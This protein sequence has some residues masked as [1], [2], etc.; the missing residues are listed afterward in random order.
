MITF[1]LLAC[2]PKIDV[3]PVPVDVAAAPV[4]MLEQPD[5]TSPD[6]YLAAIVSA[7]SAWDPAGQEGLADLTA[8]AMVEAGAGSRSGQAVRDTLYPTG[9]AIDVVVEREF[10]SFRLTCHHDQAKLCADVFADV[11][12]APR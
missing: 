1:L 12:T 9:H 3:G 6:V 11:L 4:R 5:A 7:G 10:T 8:R 2:A